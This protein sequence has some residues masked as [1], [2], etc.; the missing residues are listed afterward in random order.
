M[1]KR[2]KVIDIVASHYDFSEPHGWTEEIDGAL[3]NA[4]FVVAP[5]RYYNSYNII[6][7]VQYRNGW[8]GVFRY[9]E[10]EGGIDAF[11]MTT[12]E[13]KAGMEPF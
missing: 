9:P 11:T 6:V 5:V 12:F 4:G 8:L 7:A 3:R 2:D 13:L 10:S 1:T